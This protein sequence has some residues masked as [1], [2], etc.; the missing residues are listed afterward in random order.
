MVDQA[1]SLAVE[2]LY[3]IMFRNELNKKSIRDIAY[4][5]WAIDNFGVKSPH[6]EVRVGIEIS[7]YDDFQELVIWVGEDVFWIGVEGIQRSLSGSDSYQIEYFKG[8]PDWSFEND[9]PDRFEGDG[10]KAF[11]D[12]FD[13]LIQLESLI[14]RTEYHGEYKTY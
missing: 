5:I 11:V 8:F 6:A 9:P 4:L 2:Y 14:V 3:K 1:R 12:L 10:I 13:E 7:W